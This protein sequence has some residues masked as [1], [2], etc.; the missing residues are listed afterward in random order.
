MRKQVRDEDED[1]VNALS[2]GD[3]CGVTVGTFYPEGVVQRKW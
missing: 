3:D 2:N 1:D